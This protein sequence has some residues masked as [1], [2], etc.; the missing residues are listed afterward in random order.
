[1]IPEEQAATAALLRGLAGRAPLETHIS[2]VFVGDDTVWKLRKAVKLPFLDFTPLAE[3][4]RTALR[5]L[6]LNAPAAPG[7]YRDVVPVLRRADGTLTLEGAGAL[8]GS[9]P[10]EPVDW[11]LRMAR[12]PEADFLGAVV[13]R[14]GLTPALLDA[15][16]D[17]VAAYHQHLGPA[18]GD[19]AESQRRLTRRN[20]RSAQMSG[21]P[22][23]DIEQWLAGMQAQLDARADWLLA[24]SEAGFFRR[25]H[26]D[27]HLGNLCLW[28]GWPVP[29]DA[30]EFDE[31]LGTTDIGY[32]LAFL[33]MDLERRVD[34]AA[35]NRVLCRYLA[36]TGDYGLVAGLPL[37]LAQRA[38][39]RAFVA[40]GLGNTAEARAYMDMA[41]AYLR[42]VPP[43]VLAVGGLQG[44]GKST[45]A[46]ALAPDLGP[47]PGA[48]VLRSDELRKRRHGV[49]P[50]D[51]LPQAA[52]TGAASRAVFAELNRVVAELAGAG[53]A[54]VA[55]AMFLNPVDRSDVRAA[56]AP[57][58][59]LGVWLEAPLAVLEARIAAR[60]E[61]ASDA[62][63][64]V[65]RR[66]AGGDPGAIDWLR[67]EAT[68]GAVALARVRQC[69]VGLG[70]L[71]STAQ[72]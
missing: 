28:Q 54:V 72:G 65:L 30:L 22:A 67:V 71:V 62:T 69:L 44:T 37:F 40:S 7:L 42:P 41:L 4:R 60:R 23:A 10:G 56:A 52:Y 43:V 17:A 55:D 9:G 14:G 39:V 8:D 70:V 38:I 25:A 68:D 59:F 58:P 47:A 61:D 45:L 15:L 5:E 49:A 27:L 66:A 51:R 11:V 53:H 50:E 16:G 48:V 13:A 36:R 18:A 32:D 57:A 24:R 35:A 34:R 21:L 19:G 31:D 26:G 1:M 64:A 12:V 33:L 2:A 6:E 46:R 3:R 63:V 20:L 29:F